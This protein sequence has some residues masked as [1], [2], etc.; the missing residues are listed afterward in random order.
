ML[1]SFTNTQLNTDMNNTYS[2]ADM[3]DTWKESSKV[4]S[5]A[6]SSPSEPPL[7]FLT[8]EILSLHIPELQLTSCYDLEA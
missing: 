8:H 2:G 1:R 6:S 5:C 4:S 3:A 7:T